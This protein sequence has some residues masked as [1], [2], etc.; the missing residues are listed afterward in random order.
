MLESVF[1]GEGV[2]L[3][4]FVA[5]IVL[6]SATLQASTGFGFA[7]LSAPLLTALVGGPAAVTTITITGSVCD[8]L[9]LLARRARPRPQGAEVLRL[10][11]WSVPGLLVGAYAL[12]VL[13]GQVL[14]LVVA[15]AVLAAVGFRFQSRRP[16]G[17]QTRPVPARL[18]ALAGFSS[19]M[20]STSTTL[21]GPPVVYY[22]THRLHEPRQIRDTLVALSLVRL[23]LSVVSLVLTATWQPLPGTVGLVLAS[24]AG[25]LLG[26]IIFRRLTPARYEALVLALLMCAVL[27]ATTTA[28]L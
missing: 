2:G 3:Y 21:G 24:L 18:G 11:L 23:P 25:F 13:P 27:V 4:L 10:G 19:G 16:G 5:L 15:A 6:V 28:V 14:Q 22:L 7:I 1:T 9:I 12:A 26:G 17:H 20:L 8:L